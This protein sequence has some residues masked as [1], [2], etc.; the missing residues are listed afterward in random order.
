MIG[1]KWFRQNYK[2]AQ[3]EKKD[4]QY[5]QEKQQQQQQQQ[6]PKKQWTTKCAQSQ[7]R[8]AGVDCK[9]DYLAISFCRFKKKTSNKVKYSPKVS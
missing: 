3:K 8:G 6:T 4:K 9:I 7:L 5:Q 1:V 2:Q